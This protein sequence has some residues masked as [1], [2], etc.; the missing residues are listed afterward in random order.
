MHPLIKDL[1]KACLDFSQDSY[2]RAARVF[3]KF[4]FPV[5]P[6]SNMRRTS[7]TSIRHYYESGVKTSLPI[8]TG[9]LLA[10]LSLGQDKRVLDFG[11]GVAR[12]IRYFVTHHPKVGLYA[13]DVEGSHMEWVARA[14]PQ[15]QAHKSSYLPPLKYEDCFFDLIY[16]VSIFSHV[17]Q[18]D[19]FAWLNEFKRILKPRGVACLTILGMTAAKKAGSVR[20]RD[21]L[22]KNHIQSLETEGFV[23]QPYGGISAIKERAAKNRF[24]KN[25]DMLGEVDEGYG[26]TYYSKR[27]IRENWV[28]HGWELVGIAEGVI[29][30][31]QDLVVLRNLG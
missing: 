25:T 4:D 26:I 19:A 12:Q 8:V 30:D 21:V 11:A 29:D 9:A 13:C 17:S 16:S 1:V 24:L 2:V 14:Y 20:H 6:N 31:L 22:F 15:V 5:P 7:S 18:G 28:G 10:G 23:H 3:G 27:F